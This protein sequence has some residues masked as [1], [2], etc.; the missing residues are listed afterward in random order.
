MA[1][2]P[3]SKTIS[4]IYF[5]PLCGVNW[6]LD[7][8]CIGANQLQGSAGTGGSHFVAGSIGMTDISSTVLTSP[9]KE[10]RI[11]LPSLRV[12]SNGTVALTR[13]AQG[14]WSLNQTAGGAETTYIAA[15]LE[16]IR[17]TAPRGIKV[18]GFR[19]A[20]ELGV[21]DAT[22]VDVVADRVT[23]AQGV[24]PVVANNFG[25]AIVDGSYDSNHNTAAKRKSS[26]V[27]NGE[28]LMTVTFPSPVFLNTTATDAI[29]EFKAVLAN[30]GTLSVRAVVI[31]AT[32]V[33]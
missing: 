11:P 19:V 32:E 28:H 14:N 1:T 4:P 30:T 8:S 6:A 24:D 9:D 21:V 25:G 10:F 23:Y 29:F 3:Y 17:T 22:S 26:A 5:P 16:M 2:V 18:T 15:S 31:L 12:S 20:Y 7:G 33:Y 13:N 27:A